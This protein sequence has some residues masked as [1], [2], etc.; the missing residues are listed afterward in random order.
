MLKIRV[1]NAAKYFL[2]LAVCAI[3]F[4]DTPAISR[5]DIKDIPNATSISVLT[6][7]KAL[8]SNAGS[9][10]LVYSFA[11]ESKAPA[12]RFLL[13]GGMHGNES[14]AS[15]FVLWIAKRYARGESLLNQLA[16]DDIAIDFV[17]YL[18]PDGVTENNRY[19][20]RGVNL[21]RNFD[22]LWGITRENPGEKSFSEPETKAL[23]KLFEK[24][25][26]TAAVDVH[27]YINWIVAP[28]A[29]Q[30]LKVAGH[31]VT[32]KQINTYNAWTQAIRKNMPMLQGYQYKTGAEL[33]DGGA[34]EDWAFWKHNTL[35]YCLELETWFRFVPTKKRQFNDLNQ[36]TY[37][38]VD[39]YAQYETFV[40]RMFQEAIA[41]K[42][43]G[44]D[45][46]EMASN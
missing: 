2:I 13:Q 35:S 12:F 39:K 22:V 26:Y 18:N 46:S 34:F 10:I 45:P 29:P 14:Q 1:N 32:K 27:G 5:Q 33:G 6:G 19:N 28:S 17:P 31:K 3:A 20:A 24:Q 40:Y 21:N 7:D 9:E 25:K 37:G 38:K 41:I 44:D 16:T 36:P 30:A 42:K 43:A 23:K 15:Q 4:V 11:P 8:K